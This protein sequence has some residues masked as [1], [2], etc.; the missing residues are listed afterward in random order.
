MN[1]H[2]A[3]SELVI[4]AREN[5]SDDDPDLKRAVA[6]IEEQ[7][8]VMRERAAQKKQREHCIRCEQKRSDGLLCWRCLEA[9]PRN[10]RQAFKVACGLDVMRYADALVRSWARSEQFESEAA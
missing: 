7:C 1:F 4:F 3:L 10:V 2:A 6:R 8:T 9:A 5:G